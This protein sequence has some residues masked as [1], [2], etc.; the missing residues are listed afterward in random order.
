MGQY[1]TYDEVLKR[2]K[3]LITKLNQADW[4][5]RLLIG[6][7]L[8]LFSLVVLYILKRRIADRG[9]S[10][11][12]YLFMPLRWFLSL[13]IPSL[14]TA[15]GPLIPTEKMIE[16]LAEAGP[17]LTEVVTEQIKGSL[18][19]ELVVTTANVAPTTAAQGGFLG[20]LDAVVGE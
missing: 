1:Q 10:L 4:T 12:G 9:V 16:K 13:L 7:G 20:F 17:L 3:N 5:D 19:D 15:P 18:A 8:L 2:G 14:R 11:V 6:F